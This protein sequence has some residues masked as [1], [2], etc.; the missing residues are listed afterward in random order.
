MRAK[1]WELRATSS[2]AR[3]LDQQ[4]ERDEARTMLAEVY[5]WFTRVSTTPT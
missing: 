5:N 2:L 4:G 3:L 1:A